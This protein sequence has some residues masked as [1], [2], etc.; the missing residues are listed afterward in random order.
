MTVIVVGTLF[1]QVRFYS[2]SAGTRSAHYY[3]FENYGMS[4]NVAKA[5]NA[6]M[7]DLYWKYFGQ[8]NFHLKATKNF[9]IISN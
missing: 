3:V 1:D 4:Q 7:I 9:H 6:L 2:T 8:G 5:N